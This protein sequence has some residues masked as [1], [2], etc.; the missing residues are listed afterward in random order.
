MKG[1]IYIMLEMVVFILAIV[2]LTQIIKKTK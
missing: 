1:V 2:A